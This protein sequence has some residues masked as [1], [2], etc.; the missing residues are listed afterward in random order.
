MILRTAATFAL[1]AAVVA[2]LFFFVSSS[3]NLD[4]GWEVTREAPVRLELSQIGS[5]KAKEQLESMVKESVNF[6]VSKQAK[7]E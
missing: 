5:C 1:S 2:L 6:R 7:F 4:E 3:L